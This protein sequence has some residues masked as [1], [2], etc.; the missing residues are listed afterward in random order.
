MKGGRCVAAWVSWVLVIVGGLNWGLV[1]ALN[2]NLV[3]AIFGEGSVVSAII[4]ILVGVAAIVSIVGCRCTTC[5]PK[6][7]GAM[8]M[9]PMK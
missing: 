1:G 3:D 7:G 6:E 8:P 9:Q 2:F 4:Y 5:R